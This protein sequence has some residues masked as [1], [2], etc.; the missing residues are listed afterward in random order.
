MSPFAQFLLGFLISFFL[1]L[2]LFWRKI[3]AM[4][5]LNRQVADRRN[6]IIEQVCKILEKEYDRIYNN[7]A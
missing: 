7:P 4:K 3:S 1:P 6:V 2:A 5:H